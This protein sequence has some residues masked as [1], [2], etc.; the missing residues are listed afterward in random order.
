MMNRT[1]VPVLAVMCLATACARTDDG[2]AVAASQPPDA[3]ES[4]QP[5]S[6]S[7]PT[8]TPPSGPIDFG[9]VPTNRVPVPPGTVTCSPE[10][11]PAAEAT[12]PGPGPT[13]PVITVAVPAGF[14]PPQPSGDG[15]LITGPEDIK[16]LVTVTATDEEPAYAFETY[17]DRLVADSSISAVSV[18]PG[19]LCDYSGQELMGSLSNNDQDAVEYRDRIVHIWTPDGGMYLAAVHVTAPMGAAGFE[20]AAAVFTGDFA[21]ALP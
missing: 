19:E 21:V 10:E 1:L 6:S 5:S 11:R 20:D 4:S 16:A 8:V 18:L 15:V 12:V 14:G 2:T 17:S 9:V 13:A 7:S 3:S